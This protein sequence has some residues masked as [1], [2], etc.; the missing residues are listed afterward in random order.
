MINWEVGFLEVVIE[1]DR[2]KIEKEKVKKRFVKNFTKITMSL[3]KLMR[4][5]QK[6]IWNIRQEKLLEML[7]KRFTITVILIVL[8]LD[9]KMRIEINVSDYV[10]W[11]V[12]L[13]K[14]ANK[15]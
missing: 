13:I 9:K 11:G 1:P 14:Y 2:I 12:V 3:Y 15:R 5:E 8:D 4:K 7:K 10:I 6:W